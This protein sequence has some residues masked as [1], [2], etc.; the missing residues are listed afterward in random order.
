MNQPYPPHPQQ[1]P[2]GQPQYSPQYASQQ[3]APAPQPVKRRRVWPWVLLGVVLVPVLGFV[4]CT[5]FVG[6]GID[7]VD[8]ARKGGAVAIGETF[9]YESGLQLTVAPVA[10]YKAQNEF[11]VPD[12]HTA[13]GTTVTVVNA[14][15]RPVAAALVTINTTVNGA[16]AQQVFDTD[17]VAPTQDIAPGQ[18]LAIPFRFHVPNGTS[19]PL[20]IAVAAELNEP[21]FFTGQI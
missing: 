5:A 6:A 14:T 1:R 18:Q 2:G 11:V 3:Y 7:A 20:Q 17:F 4:A 8:K 15:D 19:G 9:T 10:P 13:Y 21:V 12:G 16:P